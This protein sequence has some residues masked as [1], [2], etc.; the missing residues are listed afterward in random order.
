MR[1]RRKVWERK[2]HG[3]QVGSATFFPFFLSRS[4]GKQKGQSDNA[5][6]QVCRCGSA[7]YVWVF[8]GWGGIRITTRVSST[9][10]QD[11]SAPRM[12]VASHPAV[13]YQFLNRRLERR[14]VVSSL[15]SKVSSGRAWSSGET[16]RP[17]Q[18]VRVDSH[19]FAGGP[20]E[21]G[22]RGRCRY[23]G[24]GGSGPLIEEGRPMWCEATAM[25]CNVRPC[26]RAAKRTNEGTE[27]ARRLVT[28]SDSSLANASPPASSAHFLAV[29]N[30]ID[31]RDGDCWMMMCVLRVRVCVRNFGRHS[32]RHQL[33]LSG[34]LSVS[35]SSISSSLTH[36]SV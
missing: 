11:F 8:S 13:S 36:P 14:N 7:V 31:A 1:H 5:A 29:A 19:V 9:R 4:R 34:C 27:P 32:G 18:A 33:Q 25:Q 3:E 20:W 17:G 22:R 2:K 12:H 15:A 30:M 16:G 23:E 24:N 26:T 21:S 6:L 10:G 35:H 28:S